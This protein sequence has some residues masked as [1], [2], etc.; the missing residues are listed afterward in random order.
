[1]ADRR[2]P[3]SWPDPLLEAALRDLGVE[4][5]MPSVRRVD[6]AGTMLLGAVADPA[7]LAR[8]RIEREGRRRPAVRW[9]S[10]RIGRPARRGLLIAA[11]ALIIVAAVAGAIGLGLPGIRIV[12]AGS[13][14]PPSGPATSAVSP[15]A[16]ERS[17]G[18]T[19]PGSPVH[20]GPVG[21]EL[22]LG[23]AVPIADLGTA[24]DFAVRL[25]SA[26]D[27]GAPET[28]WL[29]DGRLSLVWPA[30]AALPRLEEPRIGLILAEFR[31][32][33]DDGYFQ[34]I[35]EPGTQIIPVTVEGTTGWWISGEPHS[36]VF[37]DPNGRPVFD[38]RR[39]V[40]DTLMWARDG[41]TYR[42]ES[43]LGMDGAVRLAES[44]R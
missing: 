21:S 7:R 13:T 24:V 11:A 34:K 9:W 2:S 3:A 27:L 17:A 33:V 43:A 44:L 20:G 29:L 38:T 40:G 28:A 10:P 41:M 6:A 18:S 12:P 22:F 25:P 42:L 5:E 1:M 23:T 8:L 19:T 15:A 37:V 14:A 30:G 16:S 4:I 32:S 31:G 39:I 35:L 36:L 26:L